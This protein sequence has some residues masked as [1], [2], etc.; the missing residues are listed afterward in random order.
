MHERSESN[1]NESGKGGFQVT[2]YMVP[3]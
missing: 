3:E 1:V 2:E